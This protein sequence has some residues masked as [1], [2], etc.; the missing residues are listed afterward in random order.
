MGVVVG[1]DA[2]EGYAVEC[3]GLF[4][5]CGLLDGI[6]LEH[7]QRVEEG[8]G[9]SGGLLNVGEPEIEV[10]EQVGLFTVHPR[11]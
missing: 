4:G 9:C 7:R 10:V 3:V 1:S 6:R 11:Q 2:G 5:K 8:V